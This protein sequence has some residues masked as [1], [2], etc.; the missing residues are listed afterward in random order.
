[1]QWQGNDAIE[2]VQDKQYTDDGNSYRRIEL[3]KHQQNNITRLSQLDLRE[4]E[5]ERENFD[6]LDYLA[7]KKYNKN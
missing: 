3:S 1:M 2:M 4:R 6:L 7:F 5:R